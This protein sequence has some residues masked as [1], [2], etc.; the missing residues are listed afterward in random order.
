MDSAL[1]P[2]LALF[3]EAA[4]RY[5]AFIETAHHYVLA[6]RLVRCAAALAQL[7]AAGLYLPF[8]EQPAEIDEPPVPPEVSTWPAFEELTLFWQVPDAFAWSAPI[9][10]SLTELLLGTYRDVMRGLLIL[11]RGASDAADH[12]AWEWRQ[13]MERYWGAYAADA[14]R[15]LNRAIQKVSGGQRDF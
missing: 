7:Y 9:V 2:E 15:A 1:T 14:L 11:E 5:C 13:Q 12:A 4:E 6:E 8:T 3:V 10:V